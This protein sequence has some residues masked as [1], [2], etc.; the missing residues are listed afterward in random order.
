MPL[1]VVGT[2]HISKS[3]NQA[4]NLLILIMNLRRKSADQFMS[5]YAEKLCKQNRLLRRCYLNCD[6]I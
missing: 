4:K 2:H 1:L 6:Q 3:P 5:R